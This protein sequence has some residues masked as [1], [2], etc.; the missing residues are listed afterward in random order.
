[1]ALTVVTDETFERWAI[2]AWPRLG[3]AVLDARPS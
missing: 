2:D 3:Q 1:V